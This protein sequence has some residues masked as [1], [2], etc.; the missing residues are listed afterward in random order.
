[1]R[2]CFNTIVGGRQAG[3]QDTCLPV[4]AVR[5]TTLIN[6]TSRAIS[7]LTVSLDPLRVPFWSTPDWYRLTYCSSRGIRFHTRPLCIGTRNDLSSRYCWLQCEQ[8]SLSLTLSSFLFLHVD[9]RDPFH[10]STFF[11]FLNF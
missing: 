9:L 7:P 10:L 2:A 5:S 4:S 3:R 6:V 11:S 8:S 1:M